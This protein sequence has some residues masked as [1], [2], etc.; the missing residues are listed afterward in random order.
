MSLDRGG[1]DQD[2]SRRSAGS[3][4][5]LEDV[6]PH[7]FFRPA[8]KP[9][10]QRFSRTVD[11]GRIGPAAARFQHMHDAADDP[12]VI[13]PRHAARIARQVRRQSR[14]L[15]LIQPEMIVIHNGSAFGDL[16][17]RNAP[18]VNPLYGSGP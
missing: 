6:Q 17:S 4:Q 14:E 16:E 13:H 2:L 1:I 3:G 5:G 10:V 8:D 7:P 12:A 15:L 9:V 11:G 18:A